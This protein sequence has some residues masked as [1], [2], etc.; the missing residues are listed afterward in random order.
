MKRKYFWWKIM[1]SCVTIFITANCKIPYE[2][3]L[4]SAVTDALVVEGYIEGSV[5]V[6]IKLSRTRTIT[7]GDTS[8][9]KYELGAR[10]IVEDDKQNSYPLSELGNGIY[11]SL[12]NLPL[13]AAN[14]YRLHIFTSENEEY[15]SDFVPFKSSPPIDTVGWEIKDEGVQI[16]VNTHDPNNATRYYRWEYSE[17]W[18]HHTLYSSSFVYD[19]VNNVVIPR[20]QQV[21]YC[22]TTDSSTSILLGSSAKLSRDVVNEMSLVYIQPHDEKLSDLYS[23]L[24]KQYALD[25]N[26]Y[27]YL[28]AMKSNTEDLGS[29]FDPQPNET[30]GN[31]HC[32]TRPA[33]IVIGYINAG[34]SSETR[35]FI[36]NSSMPA[37]WNIPLACPFITVPDNPDSL[38]K[39]FTSEFE[40]VYFIEHP[41]AYAAST[42][43]CVDCRTQGGVPFKPSFWP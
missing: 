40:P 32:V 12:S 43:E 41:P 3:K 4:N 2:P 27:N 28:S 18:Q 42:A 8:A 38:K 34:N 13:N 16:Y 17:T 30:V 39:Y 26:G 19:E 15:L 1:A 5:P 23:I 7:N 31:I 14:R 29:I 33:E 37:G 36:S 25:S 6:I 9:R 24:V 11:S 10:V 21:Q 20:T 35:V 22:W